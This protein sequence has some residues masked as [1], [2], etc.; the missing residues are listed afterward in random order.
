MWAQ[1][2]NKMLHSPEL[3][4][5][6]SFSQSVL[7]SPQTL[8]HI[9]FSPLES[10]Q[11][12]TLSSL[13]NLVS[14]PAKSLLAGPLCRC[15]G[16]ISSVTG[17][18]WKTTASGQLS[19]GLTQLLVSA[20]AFL[21]YSSWNLDGWQKEVCRAGIKQDRTLVLCSLDSASEW[22]FNSKGLLPSP[23]P[24]LNSEKTSFWT[25]Y[26]YSTWN[27]SSSNY[28]GQSVGTLMFTFLRYLGVL[29]YR[30]L[31]PCKSSGTGSKVVVGGLNEQGA[32]EVDH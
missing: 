4:L 6:F 1:S 13:P 31:I 16:L 21:P 29:G 17:R 30:H 18:R 7:Y 20:F 22:H 2:K 19:K 32:K 10:Q 27:K 3:V 24:W 9:L 28:F 23:A 8:Y 26:P 14:P 12:P 15:N 25:P 5:K 11:W